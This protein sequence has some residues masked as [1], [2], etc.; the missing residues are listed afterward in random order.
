M[1]NPT[2]D[3]IVPIDAVDLG[4][5]ERVDCTVEVQGVEAGGKAGGF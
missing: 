3:E 2:E 1:C 4:S 5:D